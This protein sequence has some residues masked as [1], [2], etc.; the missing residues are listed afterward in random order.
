MGIWM[1]IN[2]HLFSEIE[3]VLPGE[4]INAVGRRASLQQ[5]L[6]R[7]CLSLVLGKHPLH[8]IYFDQGVLIVLSHG[9]FT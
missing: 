3:C 1:E 4:G 7:C 8:S 9:S 6:W 5:P 2:T